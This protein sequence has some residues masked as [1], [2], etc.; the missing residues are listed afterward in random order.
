MLSSHLSEG[1]REKEQDASGTLAGDA[2]I[3]DVYV[4]Q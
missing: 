2:A 4:A 3:F 1:K